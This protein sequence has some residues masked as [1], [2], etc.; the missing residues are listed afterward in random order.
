MDQSWGNFGSH[1][2]EICLFAFADGSVRGLP[3]S[4]DEVVLGYLANRKD[5]QTVEVP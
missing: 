1:H 4:I 5:D 3:K 2:P